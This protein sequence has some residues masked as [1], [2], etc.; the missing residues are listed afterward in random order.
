MQPQGQLQVL[1]NM[2]DYGMNPQAA[3]DAPRWRVDQGKSVL[4][5]Q[6]VPP[7]VVQGLAD[8]NHDVSVS[9]EP[10]DFG[11]AQLIAKQNRLLIGASEPRTDGQA[12]AY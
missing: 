10:G 3:I 1:L 5:E 4:L 8:L 2:I 11:K 7:L 12:L 9:A 6:S